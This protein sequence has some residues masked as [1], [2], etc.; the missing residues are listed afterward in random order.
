MP[1]ALAAKVQGSPAP[2]SADLDGFL[3]EVEGLRVELATADE[4]HPG[5]AVAAAHAAIRETIPFLDRDRALDGEV[6]TAVRLVRDGTVLA[7][8]REREA[9]FDPPCEIAGATSA[10]P[11]RVPCMATAVE[12]RLRRLRCRR[13]HAIA[14][15]GL[16]AIERLVGHLQRGFDAACRCACPPRARRCWR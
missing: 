10:R 11:A 8:V 14:A 16:G 13:P 15:I 3:A 5:H 7:A 6:A 1:P 4:F 12:A 9:G 2:G